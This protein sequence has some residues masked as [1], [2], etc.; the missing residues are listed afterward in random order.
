M[1]SRS[2]CDVY[3]EVFYSYT[4]NKN[5]KFTNSKLQ[6]IAK[7]PNGVVFHQSSDKEKMCEGIFSFEKKGSNQLPASS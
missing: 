2:Q 7:K 5:E 3:K 4:D 1:Y 6:K